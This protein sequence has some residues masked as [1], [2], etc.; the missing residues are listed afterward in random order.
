M[1]LP[2]YITNRRAALRARAAT[3]PRQKAKALVFFAAPKNPDAFLTFLDET[4]IPLNALVNIY[5]GWEEF[6]GG[7]SVN[8]QS[9]GRFNIRSKAELV[10]RI[11]KQHRDHIS[12]AVEGIE[13]AIQ[14]LSET[15]FKDDKTKEKALQVYQRGLKR[16]QEYDALLSQNSIQIHS[17][18]VER[19]LQQLVEI[20]DRDDIELTDAYLDGENVLGRPKPFA[21]KNMKEDR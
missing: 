13:D 8:E 15:T 19:E 4:D 21:I 10:A 11:N 9:L 3:N 17:F 6:G 20:D 1:E 7:F 5:K 18:G 14:A 2:A 16:T 12:S